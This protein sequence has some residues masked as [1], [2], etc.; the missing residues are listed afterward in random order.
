MQEQDISDLRKQ[1]VA[2]HCIIIKAVCMLDVIADIFLYVESLVPNTPAPPPGLCK[3]TS[4][5]MRHCE[6]RKPPECKGLRFPSLFCRFFN[7]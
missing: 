7:L 3:F 4:V 6:I 1:V 2:F 5:S